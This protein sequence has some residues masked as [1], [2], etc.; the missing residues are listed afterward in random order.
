MGF[1]VAAVNILRMGKMA[2]FLSSSLN[3]EYHG[4]VHYHSDF[5][6]LSWLLAIKN[7]LQYLLLAVCVLGAGGIILIT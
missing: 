7:A 4:Q 5:P 6:L 1:K 3:L 2:D